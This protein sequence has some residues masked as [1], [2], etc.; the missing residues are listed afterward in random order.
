M[1]Q[2]AGFAC[3]ILLQMDGLVIPPACCR[4]SQLSAWSNESALCLC[5]RLF[6]VRLMCLTNMELVSLRGSCRWHCVLVLHCSLMFFSWLDV[7]G[8]KASV[9]SCH[10]FCYST[11]FMKSLTRCSRADKEWWAE[12]QTMSA[13]CSCCMMVGQVWSISRFMGGGGCCLGCV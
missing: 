5:T 7:T 4:W 10:I 12:H 1:K 13:F 6:P 11:F 8:C 2:I 9:V 3:Y